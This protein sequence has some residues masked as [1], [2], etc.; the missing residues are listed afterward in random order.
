VRVSEQKEMPETVRIT[1]HLATTRGEIRYGGNNGYGVVNSRVKSYTASFEPENGQWRERYS[2]EA[3]VFTSHDDL[4]GS[5][6]ANTDYEW[7]DQDPVG[8]YH[9]TSSF[10]AEFSGPIEPEQAHVKTVPDRI[11]DHVITG[12]TMGYYEFYVHHYFAK[13]VKHRWDWVGGG[14]AEQTAAARTVETLFTGGKAAVARPKN[15]FTLTV[16]AVEYQKPQSHPWVYTPGEAV[17]A[18]RISVMGKTPGADYRVY[19]VQPDNATVQVTVEVKGAKHFNAGVGATKHKLVHQ[20]QCAALTN[21]DPE[22]L[23]LGVGEYVNFAFNPPV[24]M[25]YTEQ[26]WWLVIGG[27]S[28][29]PHFGDGTL[30]TA[31]SNAASA[32]VRVFVRDVQLD[33]VFSVKEPSGIDHVDITGTNLTGAGFVGAIAEFK[34]FFAPTSV[35]FGRVEIMEVGMPASSVTGYFTNFTAAQLNHTNFGSGNWVKLQCDNSLKD[36]AG[37]GPVASSPP[38]WANSGLTWECPARWKIGDG[39]TN[40]LDGW[41]QT[42]SIDANLTTKVEKFGRWLSRSVN[43]Q[44]ETD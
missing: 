22:R 39:P 19:T 20:T 14:W 40:S 2:G 26:P 15:L 42:V 10:G 21:P 8:T 37:F 12:S 25:T 29:M 6:S 23:S 38:V 7:S 13:G 24:N 43:G 30:F 16:G 34:V 44:I 18:S 41:T 27:G 33:T 36:A 11:I 35:S 32:T 1:K 31:P 9:F 5:S 28:V 4:E 17:P 3:S